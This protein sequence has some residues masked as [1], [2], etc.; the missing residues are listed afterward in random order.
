MRKFFLKVKNELTYYRALGAHPQTPAVSRVLLVAA[1]AYFLSPIDLI[2]DVIPVLGLLD[3]IVIVP[4]LIYAALLFIPLS[5]KRECREKTAKR[6]M[7]SD[8]I[9]QRP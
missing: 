6:S 3:D 7:P 4:G 9:K 8:T 2:P 5:V 1:I